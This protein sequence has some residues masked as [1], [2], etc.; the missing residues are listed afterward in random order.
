MVD[1]GCPDGSENCN[2]PVTLLS[3]GFTSMICVVQ[4][5]PSAKCGNTVEDATG[6]AP[7]SKT[8]SVV[9][10]RSE[11]SFSTPRSATTAT[12]FDAVNENAPE[13]AVGPLNGASFRNAA[14]WPLAGTV[15][16]PVD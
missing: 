5:P 16:D 15:V 14:I 4:P 9:Q 11:R 12:D 7:I 8:G 2:F 3:V 13:N 6:G 1:S 10:I